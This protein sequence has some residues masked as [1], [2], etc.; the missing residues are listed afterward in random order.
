MSLC[1]FSAAMTRGV[2]W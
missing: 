1:P 2:L